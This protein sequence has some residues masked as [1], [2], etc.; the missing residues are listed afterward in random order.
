[1]TATTIPPGID[2]IMYGTLGFDATL[3]EI[4][5]DW[6]VR[7]TIGGGHED[8]GSINALADLGNGA[9]LE[10]LGPHPTR[11]VRDDWRAF[12]APLH[13]KLGFWAVGVTDIAAAVERA[14]AAGY[15]PGRVEHEERRRP[16][17]LLLGW[18]MCWRDDS[19]PVIPFLIDWGETPH[20]SVDSV[21]GLRLVSLRAEHPDPTEANRRLAAVGTALEVTAGPAP[22]LIAV[23]DTPRGRIEIG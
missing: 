1:M 17:G 15:D 8:L 22:R 9:Y 11:P 7:L 18:E 21:K 13:H 2:H 12:M 5:R 3:A 16:D 4:E 23:L 6:G 19:D 10:V 20:P 14:K